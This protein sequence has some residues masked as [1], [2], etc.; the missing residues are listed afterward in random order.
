MEYPDP[1]PMPRFL[2]HDRDD[3]FTRSFESVIE[4]EGVKII[5]T[6]RGYP[7]SKKNLRYY[8]ALWLL[9]VFFVLAL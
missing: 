3:K 8:L 4:S 2:I 6:P 7:R 1:S 5:K 9:R